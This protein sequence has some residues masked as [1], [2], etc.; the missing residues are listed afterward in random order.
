MSDE[1]VVVTQDLVCDFT[2]VRAL[3]H[4]NI[5]VRRGEIFGLLGHNGAG[6]TTLIREI[7]G[8]LRPTAGSVRTFGLDPT[9]DGSQVRARTGVLT[10]YPALDVFL[11]PLENLLVYAQIHGIHH[12]TAKQRAIALLDRLGLDRAKGT[13]PARNLS[14]GLKQRVA[15]A[16]ALVHEPEM[17]LL[18]EPTSN[19]DPL[20]AR[21][22]RDLA[23]QLSREEG[24]TII[25][26]THNLSEAQE[27]CD[28][29]AVLENGRLLAI[30]THRELSRQ[31][32]TSAVHV[33][34]GSA[35][36]AA[37][38]V[39]LLTTTAVRRRR[40]DDPHRWHHRDLHRRSRSDPHHRQPAGRR[41]H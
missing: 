22:V 1:R 4:V 19:L 33:A 32:S 16:R 20:A 29:V 7:N 15:L 38:A 6:K 25:L 21:G 10:E 23:H 3:D 14:A 24:R 34:T 39:S 18:D 13:A 9:T 41:W 37:R 30:G 8:L 27:L 31:T 2:T 35:D 40:R 26:S 12:A 36:Q 17:L 11:S 28:R 5:E